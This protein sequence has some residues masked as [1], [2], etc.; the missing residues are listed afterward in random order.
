MTRRAPSLRPPAVLRLAL[1]LLRLRHRRRPRAASTAATSTRCSASSSSSATR[2][3]SRSRPSTSAAA[4]RR[5]PSRRRSSACSRALPARDELTVE[6]NPETV[7]PEL[8][9]LLARSGVDRVS[10]GAQTFEPRLLRTL[11]RAAQPDDVR[12]AFYVLR[13]AGFDNISLDLIYGIPGQKPADLAR[14]LAE[15]AGARARARLRV[16]ARGEA[17]NALH[18]RPRRGAGAPGRV[19]GVVLRA[20]RRD[21]D[22]R[23]L[24]LVRD[25]ELLP[26]R[27]HA[28]GPARAAQ[29]RLLARARLPRHRRRRGQHDRR[30]RAGA[31]RR[32]S[33]ATSPRSSAASA[34][35]R[36]LEELSAGDPRRP[37]G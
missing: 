30:A 34:P 18:A 16:R 27:T 23:R 13:D 35:P 31:T 5:S 37:S 29:P 2:S 20:R 7:T 19:D 22:R 15:A 4:R 36:E 10:L 26:H 11:E 21:A 33:G 25:G 1:R 32:R 28:A 17:R 6:A 14:D 3:P 8:A 24:P 9:A 12:R